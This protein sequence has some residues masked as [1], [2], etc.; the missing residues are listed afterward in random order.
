[1]NVNYLIKQHIRPI[2]ASAK[3]LFWKEWEYIPDGWSTK[4]RLRGGGWNDRSIA[5]TQKARWPK[6]VYSLQG[7]AP[8]TTAYTF[9]SPELTR[10]DLKTHNTLM[11]YAYVLALATRKKSKLTILDWGGG[12]GLYYLISNALLPEVKIEYYCH[13]TSLLC[14]LGRKLSPEVKFYEDPAD[15][16]QRQYDLV[17]SSSSLQY[18]ENWREVVC[19]LAAATRQYLYVTRLPIVHKVKSFVAIQRSYRNKIYGY[20]TEFLS[21]FLN[22]QDFLKCVE[23]AGMKLIREFLSGEEFSVHRAPEQGE[24]RGFLFSPRT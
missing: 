13:D 16:F 5:E 18:F 22:R 6:I 15:V 24:S 10:N 2:V 19:K 23:Q 1:M 14:Q 17:F 21:W 11:C 3:H 12:I 7:T 9:V 4:H 8:L 20:N